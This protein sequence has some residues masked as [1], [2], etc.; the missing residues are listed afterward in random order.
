MA[1]QRKWTVKI[2]SDA[3]RKFR[4][5]REFRLGD[6]RAYSAAQRYGWL[7]LVC[8]HMECGKKD[9]TLEEC[10]AIANRYT[11]KS[12]FLNEANGAYQ[13]AYRKGWLNEIC[14]HMTAVR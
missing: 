2:V 10:R 1:G 12:H 14:K 7:D 8:T 13:S 4:T 3:A 11:C 6:P 5:R 9:W